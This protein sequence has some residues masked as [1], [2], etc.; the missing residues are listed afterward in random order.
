MEEQEEEFTMQVVDTRGRADSNCKIPYTRMLGNDEQVPLRPMTAKSP[1]LSRNYSKLGTGF[2][3]MVHTD[4][5][6]PLS[7]FSSPE[8]RC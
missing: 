2:S 3:D 7:V 1:I 8:V 4:R 6:L 5:R